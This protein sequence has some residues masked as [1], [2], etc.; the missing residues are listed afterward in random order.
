VAAILVPAVRWSIDAVQYMKVPWKKYDAPDRRWQIS[1]PAPPKEK[2]ESLGAG[3]MTLR[4]VEMQSRYR[5]HIYA[6]EWVEFP[7]YIPVE[8]ESELITS[9]LESM[10]KTEK[11]TLIKKEWSTVSLHHSMHFFMRMP[12][13]KDWSGG[14]ARG[15]IVRSGNRLYILYAYVPPRE[16]LS[17]DVGE[18]FRSFRLPDND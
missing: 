12:K 8:K 16:S 2:T 18:Y 13:N 15:H 3:G 6:L 10:V 14:T 11:A 1:F 5:N 7:F 4:T 17:F 9:V